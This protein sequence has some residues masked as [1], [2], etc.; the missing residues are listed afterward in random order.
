MKIG[1]YPVHHGSV[2]AVRTL[3]RAGVPMF[4]AIEDRF[5]PTA[6]SRYLRERF[7][8]PTNGREDPSELLAGMMVI[9]ERIGKRAVLVA[10]DDE[11]AVLVAKHAD[12][13]SRHYLLPPIAEDLPR[14]L[15]SKHELVEIC[16]EL[17]LPTLAAARPQSVEDLLS[18][19]EAFGFP[20][21]LKNDQAWERLWRPGV[22]GTTIVRDAAALERLVSSWPSMMPGVVVQEYLPQEC[23]EDWITHLY[24]GRE[25]GTVLAFTGVKLRSWPPRTGVTALAVSTPNPELRGLAVSF[26]R[27][28]NYHG[29]ADLDWRFDRRDGRYKLVDF[30][31]RVGAQFRM[32]A[33]EDG[34]DVVRALHLDLTGRPVPLGRQVYDR[35]FIVG[36]L[37]AASALAERQLAPHPPTPASS[38]EHAWLAADDP[39]P[40]L[41]AGV[42]SLRPIIGFFARSLLARTGLRVQAMRARWS[43]AAT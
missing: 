8:W 7:V 21:I 15:A 34:I 9:G 4:A 27:A 23:A 28:L 3:G 11:T 30:N 32:F 37:A 6:Q 29:V 13:L 38:V 12:K 41:I 2:G 14:R 22:P 1:C 39:L 20:V 17:G 43:R 19:A 40:G 5:T 18:R 26:V 36:H 31:P 10:T 42:R 25:T 24:C 16:A 33:T 35:R